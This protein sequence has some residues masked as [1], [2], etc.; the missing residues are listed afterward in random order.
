MDFCTFKEEQR[1]SQWILIV[2]VLWGPEN[3]RY[4]EKNHLLEEWIEF[5]IFCRH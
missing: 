3:I 1:A 4:D 2:A 5:I